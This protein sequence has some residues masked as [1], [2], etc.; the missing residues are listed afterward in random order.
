[1]SRCQPDDLGI[2]FEAPGRG[3]RVLRENVVDQFDEA[4]LDAGSDVGR[5]SHEKLT[6]VIQS[7]KKYKIDYIQKYLRGLGD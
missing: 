3:R 4:L 1:M 5:I 2:C 7:I 6:Q